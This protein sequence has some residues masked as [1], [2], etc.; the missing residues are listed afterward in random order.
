VLFSAVINT[1]THQ[2]SSAALGA[3]I[4]Q[5]LSIPAALGRPLELLYATKRGSEAPSVVV[6]CSITLV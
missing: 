2:R 1:T 6:E 4:M 3:T 5:P